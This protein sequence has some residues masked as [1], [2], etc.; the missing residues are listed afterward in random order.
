MSKLTES[1]IEAFALDLFQQLGYN[2]LY[3]PNI[4]S[5]GEHQERQR[6][7]EVLLVSRLLTEGVKVSYQHDGAER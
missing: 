1:A 3:G 2:Y 6:Y 5:D 7:D 4:A